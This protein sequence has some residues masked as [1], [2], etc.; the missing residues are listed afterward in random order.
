MVRAA[1]DHRPRRDGLRRRE[2]RRR[3]DSRSSADSRA[4]SG[5]DSRDRCWLLPASA[6]ARRRH[7][8]SRCSALLLIPFAIVAYV[9][10]GRRTGHARIPRRRASHSAAALR[11]TAA[12]TSPRGVHLRALFIGLL[13][14]LALWI[15][16]RSSPR[17]PG[18]APS[19]AC[20]P[21]R[22]TW[23]PRPSDSARP[24]RRARERI[25]P[26]PPRPSSRAT[27]WPG[28]RRR[29]SPASPHR[30][31]GRCRRP[32]PEEPRSDQDSARRMTLSPRERCSALAALSF[33]TEIS[34]APPEPTTASA[35]P[36]STSA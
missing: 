5:S 10:R 28:R 14:Y 26:R 7:W 33:R 13:A 25:A 35:S 15:A 11:R 20:S 19:C 2:S 34:I 16:P 8:R 22:L 32:L 18:S 9:D 6:R 17:R 4:R 1:H 30:R 24:S 31:A 12:P 29:R 36:I 23:V 3:R 21:S 27:S